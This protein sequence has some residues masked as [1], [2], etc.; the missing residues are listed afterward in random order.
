MKGQ[1]GPGLK[2]YQ[3]VGRAG[4]RQNTELFVCF[5][6]G[7]TGANIFSKCLSSLDFSVL[8]IFVLNKLC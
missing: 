7:L 5:N 3:G 4:T 6:L 1:V 8:W 2:L